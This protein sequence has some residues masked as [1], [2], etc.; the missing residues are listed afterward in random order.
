MKSRFLISLVAAAPLTFA[1]ER[2]DS[3]AVTVPADSAVTVP[4]D[5]AVTVPTDSA[6][7]AAAIPADS[8]ATVAK[9][10]STIAAADTTAAVAADPATPLQD[11]TT[12]I[13]EVSAD[14]IAA[15]E[16]PA[17]EKEQVAEAPVAEKTI[18]EEPAKSVTVTEIGG[19][20]KGFLTAASSPY[21]VTETLV[22]GEK[23][24]L[25]IDAGVI[26]KFRKGTGL[27][28]KGGA[29][30]AI[31]DG[32]SPVILEA[33]NEGEF[34]N[35]VSVESDIRA[36][37][38]HVRISGAKIALDLEKTGADIQNI[39]IE[40]STTG[41][42]ANNSSARIQIAKIKDA[43][44]AAVIASAGSLLEV[45]NGE[46]DSNN[47]AIYAAT[48]SS[49]TLNATKVSNNQ[50]GI[51]DMGNN[52]VKDHQLTLSGNNVGIIAVDLPAE[53]LK[54]AA[55]GNA[56]NYTAGAKELSN[57]LPDIPQ[58]DI[59][60]ASPATPSLDEPLVEPE[61]RWKL[62]GNVGTEIG[63]HLVRTSHNY[64]GEDFYD[65]R[66]TIKNKDYFENY[67]QVPGLYSR[68]NTYLKLESPNG[69]QMEFTADLG[70]DHWNNWNVHNLSLN[71]TDAVR[72]VALGDIYMSAGEVYMNGAD[73]FGASY[74]TGLQAARG[75]KPLLEATLFAGEASKPKLVGEKNYDVYK[76]KIEDGEGE[77]QEMIAGGKITWNMHRRFNGSIGFVGSNDYK[78]DPFLR[79]GMGSSANT[80]DPEISSKTIFAEGN[81]LFWPGDIELNGQLAMGAA[82]TSDVQTQR[83]INDVFSKAGVSVSNFALLRKIM[84]NPTLA[85]SLSRKELEEI[86][87]DNSTMTTSE[88]RNQ[89][90]ALVNEAK[91]AEKSYKGKEDEQS[92]LT[93]WDGQNIAARVAFRW[94]F[95]K[96][97]LNGYYKFVGS[98]FY[99]AGS[100]DQLSNTREFNISVNQ[101]TTKSWRWNLAYDLDVE[102]ASIGNQ[103]NVFGLA[104]GT[105]AGL[106]GDPSSKWEK[107]H[108]QDAVRALY[109][110]NA[111]FKNNLHFGNLDV[112]LKYRANYRERN[113]A[114]RLYADYD[115]NSG[116]YK[117]SWFKTR[118]GNTT[119]TVEAEKD[120]FE[121]DSVRYM[122][123]YELANQ[124]FL[125]SGFEERLLKHTFEAEASYKLG[126]HLVKVGGMWIYRTDLS[127]FENDSL[128]DKY[129]FSNKTYGYLG[130][131]FHG[132]DF[133]EQRY[134]ISLTLN[135]EKFRNQLAFT[136]RY[137][138]YTR[139]SMKEFEWSLSD[140]FE[141]NLAK[142][143]I[144]L[145]LNAEIRQEFITRH[146]DGTDEEEADLNGSATVRVFY[147]NNLYSDYT[148]GGYYN[149]RPDSRQDQYKDFFVSASLNYAF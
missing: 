2:A 88:M 44:G 80:I 12:A 16:P 144:D 51:L 117:D 69:R 102:N 40:K 99:S 29:F 30:A 124:E 93:E 148:L 95:G 46:L 100:P 75:E 55:E 27:S 36:D 89:L 47:V 101:R 111:A 106:F 65:G 42:I 60:E 39:S 54:L 8:V 134:P 67:F 115:A 96:T 70:S 131:Y 126:K 62:S 141:I 25:I 48:K 43:T 84:K 116:V 61:K 66:D 103:Y 19:K 146:S 125:A 9:A 140:N 73:F 83:A 78:E 104:E 132:A 129:D 58:N 57:T 21:L 24:A 68:Y 6:A 112:M 133:F 37:F 118:K 119:F 52:N 20:T 15:T 77:A 41:I 13:A 5:T 113:R 86:F 91:S 26:I 81:W 120:T 79:D 56:L 135:F 17:A 34:W 7:T 11:S 74:T 3:P 138:S 136:P 28:I 35:G 50:Y 98:K 128:M 53:N 71:Y 122:Q 38:K 63:Y 145:S 49:I 31:G 33:E 108:D 147:R 94:G 87:G 72:Q 10:D 110:H 123:Y 121:I 4:A 137:K 127:G 14:T 90:E 22:V 1:Q 105:K 76:D 130:Y 85:S 18:V 114:T 109:I 59:A 23:D 149:Y 97:T 139:D 107:E 45:S 142:D 32:S 64:S 82:D 143:F 92:N